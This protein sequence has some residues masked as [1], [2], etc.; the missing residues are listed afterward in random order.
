MSS[1]EIYYS[2]NHIRSGLGVPDLGDQSIATVSRKRAPCLYF[3]TSQRHPPTLGARPT[4]MHRELKDS[5]PCVSKR[6]C[7]AFNQWV[8]YKGHSHLKGFTNLSP[9][10][11]LLYP[12]KEYF[13]VLDPS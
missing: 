5:G 6:R 3:P 2:N 1:F 13:K 9:E 7:G 11:P 4:I 12:N 10:I 8:Y